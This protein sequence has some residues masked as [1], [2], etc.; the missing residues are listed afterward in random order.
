MV[1]R[2]RSRPEQNKRGGV[3]PLGLLVLPYPL[4]LL[5]NEDVEAEEGFH[6]SAGLFLQLF[7][8]AD[9]ASV[10]VNH[11]LGGDILDEAVDF[12]FAVFLVFHCFGGG[13]NYSMHSLEVCAITF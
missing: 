7:F 4:L 12:G 6:Q 1:A 2:R 8:R 5:V 9:R 13:E 11:R 10:I 3:S